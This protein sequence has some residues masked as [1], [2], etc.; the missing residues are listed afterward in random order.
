MAR[1]REQAPQSKRA[2]SQGSVGRGRETTMDF[3][4]KL[5]GSFTLY[6]SPRCVHGIKYC[7]YHLPKQ[8]NEHSTWQ[9]DCAMLV[10]AMPYR[11]YRRNYQWNNFLF[12]KLLPPGIASSSRNIQAEKIIVD[13]WQ[14]FDVDLSRLYFLFNQTISLILE[15]PSLS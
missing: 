1:S 14:H 9:V 4:A 2:G 11:G 13:G 12:K 6:I 5:F 8:N 7:N 15:Y 10:Q 3:L